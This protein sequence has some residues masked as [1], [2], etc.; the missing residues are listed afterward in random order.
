[1]SEITASKQRQKKRRNAADPARK[2]RQRIAR[3]EGTIRAMEV[4]FHTHA[5][6]KEGIAGLIQLAEGGDEMS[7]VLLSMI[8]GLAVGALE[9]IAKQ[10]PHLVRAHS[11]NTF[12][13]PGFISRKS[14]FKKAN[15]ELMKHLQLGEGSVYSRKGWQPSAPS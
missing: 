3:P 5:E 7:F 11:R 6:A 15:E 1:M 2:K 14:A 13:W 4:K 10:R 8:A 12:V 9:S